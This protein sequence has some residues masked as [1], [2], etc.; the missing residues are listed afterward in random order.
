MFLKR[1]ISSAVTLPV[2][3]LVIFI[4]IMVIVA[5]GRFM[6]HFGPQHFQQF[7]G[8]VTIV[9][10]MAALSI[11]AVCCLGLVCVAFFVVLMMID[12]IVTGNG[13]FWLRVD[14][15]DALIHSDGSMVREF[16][17]T[18]LVWRFDPMIRKSQFRFFNGF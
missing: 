1:V 16:E 3:S 2:M 4:L 11:L 9:G 5:I 7:A 8:T 13:L 15:G 12:N 17:K 14:K 18:D 6:E 10:A